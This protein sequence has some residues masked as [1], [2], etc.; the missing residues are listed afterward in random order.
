MMRSSRAATATAAAA[1]ALL[2]SAACASTTKSGGGNERVVDPDNS[3][4][5]DPVNNNTTTTTVSAT[6]TL[7][8]CAQG[9]D[10]YFMDAHNNCANANLGFE[11]RGTGCQVAGEVLRDGQ[12]VRADETCAMQYFRFAEH[13]YAEKCDAGDPAGCMGLGNLYHNDIVD[14]RKEA[15]SYARALA[16]YERQCDSSV[17]AGCFQIGRLNHYG[18]AGIPQDRAQAVWHLRKACDL[19]MREAC[20]WL[21]SDYPY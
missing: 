12:G 8:T 6:P 18:V 19:G 7:P 2:L 10:E 4:T 17:A 14:Q 21:A 11:D 16:I 5:V 3:R 9:G 20:D 15:A 13:I 1:A